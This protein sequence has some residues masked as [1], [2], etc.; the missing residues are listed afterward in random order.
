ML[1]LFA[2]LIALLSW[3]VPAHAEKRVALVIGNSS[4]KQISPLANPKN[5][6][7]LMAATL[8]DVG[9]EVVTAIDVDVRQM[10]RAVRKFGKR[11]R[12]SGKD[13]V[14]LFYYAGHGIQSQGT[15][16]LV[17]LGAQ[18][19]D[20]ADL[21]IE[22]LSASDVL[23][24]M[25]TA[26]NALNLVVLDACRNNPMASRVRSGGRGLARIDAASGS[27]IAFAAAP[28]Q[29]ADDGRGKNS[30]YTEAFVDALRQPGLTV[31]QVFK[32]VRVRVEA[33]TN[34]HQTP[35]EESSL[36]G[37]FYFV[38]KQ[39]S[40]AIDEEAIAWSIVR[41]STVP[42]PV[43][44]FINRHPNG[45]FSAQAEA[46][47]DRLE[48]EALAEKAAREAKLKAALKEALRQNAA[49]FEVA[50]LPPAEGTTA[51]NVAPKTAGEMTALALRHEEGRGVPQSF[52]KA[53]RWYR[54]AVE[55]GDAKARFRLGLLYYNGTGV[56]RNWSK[57]A[58]QVLDAVRQKYAPAVD[59][60]TKGQ[61]LRDPEFVRAIQKRLKT[62][63]SYRSRIDGKWGPGSQNAVL[64]H[65]GRSTLQKSR[66]KAKPKLSRKKVSKRSTKVVRKKRKKKG[67]STACQTHFPGTPEQCGG[68]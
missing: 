23:R 49:K 56:T 41:D 68:Y 67:L 45:R 47:L 29:V 11:L 4:Y 31:E 38:P 13:A 57:A 59:A 53:V 40:P 52:E 44:A 30:P 35:W 18:I 28:G 34:G 48:Q 7:A 36:R 5:D 1:R 64:V 55:K 62:F 50:A 3:I 39:S 60:L 43:M 16:Y 51:A 42:S 17:P 32:R 54:A 6:A 9:F 66:K 21:D 19:E 15:N 26:G 22:T 12:R 58:T 8:K 20:E 24:Q 65:S 25:E 61:D 10:G 33:Q 27:L 37:D 63:G 46:L 2:T 14:G